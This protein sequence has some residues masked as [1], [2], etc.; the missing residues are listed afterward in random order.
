[1]SVP[2]EGQRVERVYGNEPRPFPEPLPIGFD[3]A[4]LLP[5]PEGLTARREYEWLVYDQRVAVPVAISVVN[6]R[7][8]EEWP[9]P[10]VDF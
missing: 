7:H 5:I 9:P 8:P 4:R 1:V 6:A 2:R 10:G 3:E